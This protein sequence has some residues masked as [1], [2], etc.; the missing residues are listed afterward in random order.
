MLILLANIIA[1]E[2]MLEKP[3]Q[4]LVTGKIL[5]VNIWKLK[6]K[7]KVKTI[8]IKINPPSVAY[9]RRLSPDRYS[10]MEISNQ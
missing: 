8:K 5:Y 7:L 3:R 9:L 4:K 10:P 6:L 2:L 1:F